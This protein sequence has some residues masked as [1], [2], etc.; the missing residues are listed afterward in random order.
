MYEVFGQGRFRNTLPLVPPMIGLHPATKSIWRPKD[1]RRASCP[2][3]GLGEINGREL[4]RRRR[5]LV[6]KLR[7]QKVW[8]VQVRVSGWADCS[9]AADVSNMDLTL[10]SFRRE[11]RE[12]E[13]M[14]PPQ[15]YTRFTVSPHRDKAIM[16]ASVSC[17]KVDDS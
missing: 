13:R 4:V 16:T 14:A 8:S 7:S 12:W 6:G 17:S 3:M 15:F 10:L 5:C 9:P 11:E 2:A 1:W